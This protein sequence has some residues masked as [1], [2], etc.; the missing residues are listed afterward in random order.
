MK[1]PARLQDPAEMFR[2]VEP[3]IPDVIVAGF[4]RTSSAARVRATG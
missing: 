2:L 4:S 3:F 1:G